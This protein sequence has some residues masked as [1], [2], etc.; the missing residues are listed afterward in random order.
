MKK[1]EENN[2]CNYVKV[3]AQECAAEEHE[4]D[5]Q[6]YSEESFKVLN[7]NIRFFASQR[8]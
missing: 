2:R 5:T 7:N 6:G 8:Y 4:L 3:Y 1:F